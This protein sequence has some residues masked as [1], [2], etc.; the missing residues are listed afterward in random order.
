MKLFVYDHCP[1]CVRAR[2]P[3]GLK[4]IPFDLGFQLNDDEETPIR[5]IGAK[6]LPILQDDGKYMGESLD[7][8]H[9]LDAIDG[10][11]V[12]G[13]APDPALV[14][15]LEKWND[16]INDLVIPRTPDPVYPEFATPEAIAYFTRKKTATFGDFDG[17]KARTPELIA[18]LELGLEA[19]VPLLPDAEGASINDILLFPVLRSLSVMD[20]IRYP[21]AVDAY[22]HRMAERS[23]VPLVGALRASC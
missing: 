16:V 2:I 5:M 4:D 20:G 8:V 9:Y 14:E 11:P 23:G 10:L 13:G 22:R 21:A 1:F 19:L 7:I 18:S 15:W 12:F 3:F 6:M 17:L